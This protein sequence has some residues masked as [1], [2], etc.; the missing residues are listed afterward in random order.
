MTSPSASDGRARH[1]AIS[2]QCPV[3][4]PEVFDCRPAGRNRDPRMAPR[5]PAGI[6]KDLGVGIA[7]DHMLSLLE[8][9]AAAHPFQPE[10]YAAGAS[11]RTAGLAAR[12]RV[13]KRV[14]ESVHG[15]DESR[16]RWIVANR[17][18]NLAYEVREVLLG[19][20]GFRPQPLLELTFRER[21][22]PV[23]DEDAQQVERLG[24]QSAPRRPHAAAAGVPDRGCRG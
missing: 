23:C 24:R 19:H 20:E 6:Q 15:P 5:D 13:A 3:L 21:L 22:G 9:D 2:D 12:G 10:R 1:L 17:L 16:V 18:A 11:R 14:A 7:A 8:R 4:A